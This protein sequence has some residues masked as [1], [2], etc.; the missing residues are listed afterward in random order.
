MKRT[1]VS[2]LA[3]FIASVNLACASTPPPPLPQYVPS[4]QYTDDF[5]PVP[6]FRLSE[7]SYASSDLKLQKF[8]AFSSYVTIHKVDASGSVTFSVAGSVTAEA[9]SYSVIMDFVAYDIVPI[10]NGAN[11]LIAYG[12]NGAGLRV[13]ANIVTRSASIN[14]SGLPNLAVEA[15]ASN[16]TGTLT[17]DVIGISSES[18]VSLIPLTSEIDPTS[19]GT[20]LQALAGIKAQ[21]FDNKTRIS[22][23]LLSIRKL[24][25][26]K[27]LVADIA[28]EY[29]AGFKR[30]QPIAALKDQLV[31]DFSAEKLKAINA[32]IAAGEYPE[33]KAYFSAE[34]KSQADYMQLLERIFLSAK[35]F[36]IYLIGYAL[37]ALP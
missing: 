31:A 7:E 5:Q 1:L 23:Y 36:D 33:L 9:G 19:I 21:I 18:V 32:K 4:T 34:I 27:S 16:L 2:S 22:P 29:I 14:L 35:D 25:P 20:I 15:K 10:R 17:V 8:T 30:A 12:R 13:T 3:A 6:P 37:G 11:Q 26:D 24:T 28:G